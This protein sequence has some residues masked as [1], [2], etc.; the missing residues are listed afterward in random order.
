MGMI[1]CKINMRKRMDYFT[2]WWG[3][4]I[5]QKKFVGNQTQQTKFSLEFSRSGKAWIVPLLIPL[6]PSPYHKNPLCSSF[7]HKMMIDCS[8]KEVYTENK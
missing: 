4:G 6:P 1:I 8:I 2:F 5:H 7:N 3:M